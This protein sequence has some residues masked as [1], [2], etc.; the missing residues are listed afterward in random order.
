MVYIMFMLILCIAHLCN[1][2]SLLS[3]TLSILGSREPH[4]RYKLLLNVLHSEN[5]DYRYMYYL[6]LFY[7]N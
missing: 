6:L 7:K 2:F 5:K 3:I 4:G 1:F